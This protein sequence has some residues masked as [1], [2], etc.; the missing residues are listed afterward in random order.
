[1]EGRRPVD[2]SVAEGMRTALQTKQVLY[3]EPRRLGDRLRV[4][5]L[6]RVG[7]ADGD[8]LSV[9]GVVDLVASTDGELQPARLLLDDGW[10]ELTW[11]D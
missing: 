1:M 7:E 6:E 10:L 2:F 3:L 11:L 5:L 9:A 4:I 8:A